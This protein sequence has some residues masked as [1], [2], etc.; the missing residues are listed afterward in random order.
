MTENENDKVF[1]LPADE[2]PKSG[3]F[4]DHEEFFANVTAEEME[5]GRLM[6]EQI[7]PEN[8]EDGGEIE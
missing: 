4:V 5:D 7:D 1:D 8:D 6:G 3:E 2:P